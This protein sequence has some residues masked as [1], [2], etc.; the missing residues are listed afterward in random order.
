M[1]PSSPARLALTL[2]LGVTACDKLPSLGSTTS[3]APQPGLDASSDPGLA[4]APVAPAR[5][6]VALMKAGRPCAKLLGW[7]TK[8]L[9]LLTDDAVAAWGAREKGIDAID[10]PAPL[11]R[12][13]VH[14]WQG[15]GA[16]A[17]APAVAGAVR[18]DPD[19]DVVVP[20]A[21]GTKLHAARAR[22]TLEALGALPLPA[23]GTSPYDREE[24]LPYVAIV[25]T[26]DSQPPGAALPSYSTAAARHQHGVLMAL[27]VESVRCLHR[28]PRCISRQFFAQAFPYDAKHV[29]PLPSGGQR[30]SLGSLA[31]AIGEAVARWRTQPDAKSSPLVINLSLGWDLRHG[32]ALP[33]EHHALL[34]L[35]NPNPDVP[36]TVQAVH[37]ALTWAACEGA[38]S[39]AA[40]GNARGS[41]CE[42]QGTMAPAA[43]EGLPAPSLEACALLGVEVDGGR[44]PARLAYG[45]AGLDGADQ[46]IANSRLGSMPARGLYA[47][48]AV[49]TADGGTYTQAWTGTSVATAALSAIAA[50]AWGYRPTEP[51]SR[52]V[53]LVDGSG[54]PRPLDARWQSQATS[55]AASIRRI[56]AHAA[57]D[58]I[59]PADNP[60]AARPSGPALVLALASG[61]STQLYPATSSA[62]VALTPTAHDAAN[63]GSL[64]VETF[65]AP[66][67]TGSPAQGSTAAPVLADETRPQPHVPICP[68][69]PVVRK[70][71]SGATL[72]STTILASLAVEYTLYVEIDPQYTS[73]ATVDR[74][75]LSFY[76]AASSTTLAVSLGPILLS[77]PT[78][79]A[80][81]GYT[82]P[83]GITVAEWLEAHPSVTAGRLTVQVDDGNGPRVVT[84]VVDVVRQP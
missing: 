33:L 52:L 1:R 22:R 63:C 24:G 60:Y 46:P 14:A 29:E 70:T 35:D 56:D 36:A 19:L 55:P 9:F 83:S 26:A 77:T 2:L 53:D 38:L 80:L 81:H 57:L 17:A 31:S 21:I 54:T 7:S 40:A 16:P 84:E 50:Q 76:D 79:I 67:G 13:C 48:R 30:G 3:D 65:G 74:P 43:W 27:L 39:L 10:M 45:A 5:R 78:A 6:Y 37:H 32:G 25:D 12:F 69:C 82:L 4:P 51:A 58:A 20:Q 41:L 44:A 62:A 59:A 18:V 66:D 28:E 47:M 49:A 73:I 71:S 15:A 64:S 72:G 34:D 61:V 11:R 75:A 8:P 42:E 23:H 68:N